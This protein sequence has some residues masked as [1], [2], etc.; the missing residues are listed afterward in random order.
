[1]P[2]SCQSW[3]GADR[4]CW[5]LICDTRVIAPG[6]GLLP[7]GFDPGAAG[8]ADQVTFARTM[9]ILYHVLMVSDP[10]P[11]ADVCRDEFRRSP[12]FPGRLHPTRL[13]GGQP[14]ISERFFLPLILCLCAVWVFPDTQPVTLYSVQF[15]E[16]RSVNLG[17]ARTPRAPQAELYAEVRYQ[18]GQAQ[19][20]LR[21]DRMKP[22]ILFGRDVT[23]YVL[24]A[25]TR[26]GQTENLGEFWAR[27]DRDRLRFSTGLKAF[28]LM[29][30]AE[31]YY[32]VQRPS[33]LVIFTS[34]ASGDRQAGSEAFP[35]GDF[36]PAPTFGFDTI[37]HVRYDDNASV[38]LQQAQKAFEIAE[39]MD[40]AR[41]A[42]REFEEARAFLDRANALGRGRYREKELVDIARRAVHSSNE[43]INLTV[44]R[45]EAQALEERIAQRQAEMDA[46]I[47]RAAEAE[48]AAE[49]ARVE[50]ETARQAA[51]EAARLRQ[52]A[53]AE[54]ERAREQKDRLVQ[55]TAALRVE[56]DALRGRMA[57]LRAEM[58]AVQLEKA[59]LR[60][61]L[62]EALSQVA[63]TRATARGTILNLPDI[64]FE[65]NKADLKPEL[66]VVLAK[67]A[68][69]LLLMPDLNLRVEGHTDSTGSAEYNQTLSERRAEAV[70]G[71]L[72]EQGVASRRIVSVGYGLTRPIEDN[73]TAAGRQRNRRVEL[74]IAEGEVREEV[75]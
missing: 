39:R 28:A 26:D 57:D 43:A 63:E 35:F 70:A 58:E 51:G 67:L 21:F 74:V 20:R 75:R 6:G 52:E 50:T 17:F 1:M 29:I 66:R 53:D 4:V 37:F 14:M 22:A 7:A 42:P 41:H 62:D 10:A 2:A 30:T 23:C 8:F 60:S 9:N 46:L 5:I 65:V 24:W 3:I 64:L 71:F 15:P 40:A 36:A 72:S 32:L 18:A 44:R 68:G 34:L 16:Q 11:G 45:L 69:I 12:G 19:I 25:V 27:E 49:R 59:T 48:Q 55:E 73:A 33:E 31:S 13:R 54:L 38:D 61:H 47:A 56:Q